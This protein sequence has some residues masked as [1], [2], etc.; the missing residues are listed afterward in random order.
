LIIELLI[1]GVDLLAFTVQKEV[2]DR[3]RANENAMR[4][5]RC[6]FMAQLLSHVENPA[7]ASPQAFWPAPKSNRALVQMHRDDRL[8]DRARNLVDSFR[9][10]SP[11]DA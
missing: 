10:Y 5:D 3:L 4:M 9:R 7:H 6:R 8:G 2:A 11:R 1:A